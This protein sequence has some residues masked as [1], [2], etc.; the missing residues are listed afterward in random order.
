METGGMKGKK[1]EIIRE[2][3]HAKI[4]QGLGVEA[5]CSEY[6]MAELCSQAYS[7]SGGIFQCSPT[8]RVYVKEISDPFSISKSTGTINII[9][10]ANFHSC[11]FIETQDL[12]RVTGGGFEVLGRVDNSE[13][14][15]CNLLL[16]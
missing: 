16:A 5:V 2:G 12:G 11:S 14:R 13:A 4:R 10:L 3:L 15:G 7:T 9:D 6:G 1:E 8:M